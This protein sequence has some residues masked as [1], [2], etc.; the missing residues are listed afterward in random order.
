MSSRE[1]LLAAAVTVLRRGEP[2]TLDAVARE[3]G[4]SK[5]GVVHHFGTKDGLVA[6]V[7]EHVLSAW[8]TELES[9]LTG[10][11]PS[12]YLRAYVDHAFTAQFD[13]SDL[14]MLLDA[15]TRE[16]FYELWQQRLAP[17]L[18]ET[19]GNQD[20]PAGEIAAR[21]LADGYWIN[22]AAGIETM[23][24]SEKQRV[25]QLALDLLARGGQA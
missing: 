13:P 10:S 1:G 15:R 24:D 19:G 18:G 2:L 11:D 16:T 14:A 7:V 21:L 12:A 8:E 22:T 6:A 23:N 25:H 9:L 3:G 4:L 17:W 20:R 5:P